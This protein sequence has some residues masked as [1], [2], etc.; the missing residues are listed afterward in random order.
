MTPPFKIFIPSD[1]TELQF[2]REIKDRTKKNETLFE[3]KYT[4]EGI[5]SGQLLT[6]TEKTLNQF[7]K[8]K[9]FIEN[10]NCT[11]NTE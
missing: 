6:L 7:L 3:Y 5:K 8:E 2:T 11:T 10:E 4:H 9:I 1:K